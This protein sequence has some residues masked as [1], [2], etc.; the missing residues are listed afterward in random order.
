MRI[1]ATAVCLLAF[2][3][4]SRAYA[5]QRICDV[6]YEDCRAPLL[7]LIAAESV[8][9]DTAFWFM[10]DAR[11]AS[12]LIARFRAGVPVRVLFDSE[13]VGSSG[14]RREILNALADAG[15]PLRDKTGGGILHWKMMLFAGRNTV[16]FS[17]ANYS[18]Y[19]FVPVAPYSDY[20]DE[21]VYFT[22]TPSIVNSFKRR[23]D[24]VW[25]STTGYTDYANVRSRSRAYPTY[26]IDPDLNFVPWQ[27]FASRSANAYN[28]ETAGIDALIY[29]ITDRRHTDAIIAARARGVPVR[30]VTEQEQY[31]DPSRLWH[32]WN[33]DRL[34]M[35]GV[36]VRIRAHAGLM[37]EKLTLLRSRRM[38]IFGSS[39]WTGPS[40]T[41]QLE[42][43]LF[44]TDSAF[45]AW[46]R[47]HFDRKWNNT[48]P[49][50]ETQPFTLL[51]PD[52]PVL[53][54]PVDASSGVS[55]SVTLAWYA[56]PW[57]HKYDVYLGTSP[58]N[59]QLVL[60]DEEL[61]PSLSA[62]DTVRHAVA[63]LAGGT[64]YYW[65]VVSRTMANQSRTS[66]VW[67]FTTGGAA[68]SQPPLP[69]PPSPSCGS[70]PGAGAGTITVVPTGSGADILWQPAGSGRVDR[71]RLQNRTLTC[72]GVLTHASDPGWVVTGTGFFNGDSTADLLFHH[73]GTGTLVAWLMRSGAMS[74][75]SALG[76]ASDLGWQ[77]VG[78][79]NFSG[80]SGGARNDIV[81]QHLY[82]GQVV[83]W[84][85]SGT[86]YS[87]GRVVASVSDP[88]WRVRAVEDFNGDGHADLVWQHGRLGSVLVWFM[89]GT[90][91]V[92][93]RLVEAV[94]DP[95]WEIAGAAELDGNGHPDL[96]W[97]HTE[98]GALVGW[99]MNGTTRRS[100]FTVAR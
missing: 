66:P 29:R 68:G 88:A 45:Y 58:T 21:I 2:L 65:Q 17:G 87:S 74:S 34:Y 77:V 69:P 5:L 82:T 22:D 85:M 75:A 48:G 19:A 79:H 6:A 36:A 97:R 41:S 71:W 99:L 8:R 10:E 3:A 27:N 25:T 1:A 44:T 100:A 63:G 49:A 28:A 92:G 23:F 73:Q 47:A 80:Q 32:A 53:Q 37:H 55:T 31:R 59:L 12:A 61:G 56:G 38:A 46:A 51:P 72:G 40:A 50:A 94:D 30:L 16:Q 90:G 4:P 67:S 7:D 43:N 57:A 42:H 95:R 81:W 54:S 24:D 86:R 62:S 52:P 91:R 78:A 20:V 96:L 93:S 14:P 13:A 84:T 83:I 64:T 35:A 9:I 11:Y 60:G 26:A 76:S 98:T 15:I 70:Q 33:V 89:R 39:N 18:P